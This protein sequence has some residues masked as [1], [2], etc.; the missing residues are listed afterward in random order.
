MLLCEF[1]IIL[2]KGK[3]HK[4]PI[5]CSLD[6]LYCC[7]TPSF[8]EDQKTFQKDSGGDRDS[9]GDGYSGGDRVEV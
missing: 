4:N 9:G 6:L 5:S 1:I 2:L 3:T 8:T 7:R